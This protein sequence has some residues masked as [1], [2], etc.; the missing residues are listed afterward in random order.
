[1]AQGADLIL[2]D[3]ATANLDVLTKDEIMIL[4]RELM[5]A[6]EVT[7]LASMHDVELAKRYCTRII[8]LKGGRI[9]FDAAPSDLDEQAV[10]KVMGRSPAI[11]SP[12]T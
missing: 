12:G 2:A 7:V 9:T 11:A 8:G 10:A 1:M 6:R 4:L 3:E 5:V